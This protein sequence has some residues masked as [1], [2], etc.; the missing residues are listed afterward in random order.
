[1]ECVTQNAR[2]Q[3]GIM[4]IAVLAKLIAKADC[5]K[6]ARMSS[7]DWKFCKKFQKFSSKSQI[8]RLPFWLVGDIVCFKC[9]PYAFYFCRPLLICA[10]VLCIFSATV[11]IF[12]C[13][14]ICYNP[15]DD[16][17]RE[18]L[19]AGVITERDIHSIQRLKNNGGISSSTNI[20]RESNVTTRNRVRTA[21]VS[22]V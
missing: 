21:R 9:V 1:M 12:Q 17:E 6:P 18:L 8:F 3:L 4:N 19:K 15:R 5:C 13:L 11:S 2:C 20:R 22:P 10:K 7:V 14:L 16:L